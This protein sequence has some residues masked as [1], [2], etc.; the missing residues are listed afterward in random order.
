MVQKTYS[1][2]RCSLFIGVLSGGVSSCAGLVEIEEGE[3]T[4]QELSLQCHT[5]ARISFA[6]KPYVQQV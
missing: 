3:L 2:E 6:K 1:T 4:G 5:L